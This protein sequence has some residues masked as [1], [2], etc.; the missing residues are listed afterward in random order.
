MNSREVRPACN[1]SSLTEPLRPLDLFV[2]PAGIRKACHCPPNSL[3]RTALSRRSLRVRAPSTPAI[4]HAPARDRA[5]D[6]SFAAL[7]H[8]PLGPVAAH[9]TMPRAH[10]E[11]RNMVFPGQR[12]A[13]ACYRHE[14]FKASHH[15]ASPPRGA[16]AYIEVVRRMAA[17][18]TRD[19]FGTCRSQIAIDPCAAA[20][21]GR[22]KC[23][24]LGP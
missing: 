10:A 2:N 21:H 16:G 18:R 6:R 24:R 3:V 1:Q 7:V 8:V 14:E 4:F 19:T 5:P 20:I 12:D 17:T 22:R 15:G 13:V 9:I 23:R 11:N